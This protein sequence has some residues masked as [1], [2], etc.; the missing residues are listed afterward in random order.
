MRHTARQ[1]ADGL[2]L[3]RLPQLRLEV[4]PLLFRLPALGHVHQ[5]SQDARL[6]VQFDQFQGGQQ[7]DNVAVLAATLHVD[8]DVHF[9]AKFLGDLGAVAGVP[10]S[11]VLR[12]APDDLL[13]RVAVKLD[14]GVVGVHKHAVPQPAD[15][16]RYRAVLEDRREAGFALLEQ[17]RCTSDL[18]KIPVQPQ[19][20]QH[21]RD[22]HVCPTLDAFKRGRQGLAVH[23]TVQQPAREE[24]PQGTNDGI[25]RRDLPGSGPRGS[26]ITIPGL[27]ALPR[28]FVA[29]SAEL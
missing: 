9:V 4:L 20:Q 16:D 7:A 2:H 27:Q 12:G 23:K 17:S 18:A 11:Q 8:D 6:A 25:Y 3:L 24:D 13:P 29:D 15:G 19:A 22:H 26:V 1:P 28:L 14:E 21:C 5:R 10:Q